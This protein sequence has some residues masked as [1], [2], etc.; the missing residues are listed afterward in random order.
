[1]S[2]ERELESTPDLEAHVKKVIVAEMGEP[3]SMEEA[4]FIA[5]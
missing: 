4:G 3:R 1:M 2:R 5:S